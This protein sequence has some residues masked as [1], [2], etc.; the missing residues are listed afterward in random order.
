M[1]ILFYGESEMLYDRICYLG[2]EFQ[3]KLKF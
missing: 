1:V 3:K 2:R